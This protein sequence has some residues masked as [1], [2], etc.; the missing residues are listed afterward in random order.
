MS[1][2]T[3][4][5]GSFPEKV[6]VRAITSNPTTLRQ[7]RREVKI[8]RIALTFVEEDDGALQLTCRIRPGNI[9]VVEH[10]W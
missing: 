8:A 9:Q 1:L 7:P 4:S 10:V 3:R 5:E 2:H 6:C